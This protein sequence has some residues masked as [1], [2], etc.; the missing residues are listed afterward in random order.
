MSAFEYYFDLQ[1]GL[2]IIHNPIKTNV[3]IHECFKVKYFFDIPCQLIQFSFC[4]SK[5]IEIMKLS[6]NWQGSLNFKTFN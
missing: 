5:F 3:K 1:K 2:F 4:M 6:Y